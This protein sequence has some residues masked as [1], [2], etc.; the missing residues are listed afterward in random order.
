MFLSSIAVALA[1]M[2][3]LSV[4]MPTRQARHAPCTPDKIKIRKDFDSMAP[5]DRKAYTD[6]VKC[7]A[8]KPSQLDQTLYPAATN[9]YMDYAVIH[10]NR[11]R[12]V[13]LSGFFLTWH[14]YFIHLFEEDLK[15]QCN[16]T[17]AFPYWNWPATADNL[18][19]S[20]V[21][22]GSEYS[23]SGDGAYV[24]SGPVVLSPSLSL[25]HG[26][27]GGCI[28]SGP[29]VDW[30]TTMQPIPISYIIEGLPLPDT[31]FQL[32]QSC[33]TRDLNTVVA[34]TYCNTTA[35]ELCLEAE[36]IA[37]FD[38]QINGVIGGGQ[39]GLHSGAHFVVGSPGSS[40]YVSVMDPIWWSLH[41]FL[42]NVYTSWQIRH[43]DIANAMYGTETAVNLPASA[44][45]T[46]DS[47]QPDWGY[48]QEAQITVGELIST[49]SGP[50]CYQY[51]VAL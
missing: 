39:L 46:L 35:L 51:D 15:H 38:T 34:Q 50:F 44:N 21:F 3:S 29:F 43:P 30:Q 48:F 42:D 47:I 4:A 6:A 49:T 24:D 16:Y 36:D 13:H 37:S 31:A 27:G 2:S 19:G 45:V 22:D 23:L 11:T 33:L 18:S 9:R 20:A 41:A 40:I 8:T 10:V 14:R 17:G 7:L 32:N 25:P 28:M 26:S 12:E 1:A 5:E